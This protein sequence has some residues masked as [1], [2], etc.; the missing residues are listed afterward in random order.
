MP[1]K[2]AQR[3]GLKTLN[4]GL[5]QRLMGNQWESK[6]WRAPTARAMHQKSAPLFFTIKPNSLKIL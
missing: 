3:N 1:N 6:K 4:K 2:I 5:L